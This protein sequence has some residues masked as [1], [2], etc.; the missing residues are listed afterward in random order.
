MIWAAVI[1]AL[2]ALPISPFIIGVAAVILRRKAMLLKPIDTDYQP[3]ET[4]PKDTPEYNPYDDY[5]ST[6]TQ[7][8]SLF[9][10][11]YF[12]VTFLFT[13]FVTI[14]AFTLI[15]ANYHKCGAVDCRIDAPSKAP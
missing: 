2:A 8:R 1:A 6:Y 15:S 3:D 10:I 12:V 5:N 9:S 13:A 11:A 4:L 14:T 7:V